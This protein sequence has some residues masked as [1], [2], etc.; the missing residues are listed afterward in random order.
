MTVRRVLC[1]VLEAVSTQNQAQLI[2]KLFIQ[3]GY[4]FALRRTITS[5][6]FGSEDVVGAIWFQLAGAAFLSDAVVPYLFIRDKQKIVYVTI[7][8]IPTKGNFIH[9]NIPRMKFTAVSNFVAKCLKEA[10]LT[11]EGVVHHGVDMDLANYV[12]SMA[13]MRRKQL[14]ERFGD[15][16]K[17]L[18]VGRNDPRKGLNL[19]A[20]AVRMLNEKGLSK[21][22]VV[23][24]IT[25]ESAMAKFRG[26]NNV[27]LLHKQGE[28]KYSDVILNMAA[29]DYGV[30]PTIC[31]GFGLPLLEQNS[32][33]R[34]VLHAWFEPLS[35][36][37]SKDYNY[38]YNYLD[39]EYVRCGDT[40]YW[41]FHLYP[42]Q[43][44]A[45][46]MRDAIDLIRNSR[47]EYEHYCSE[48]MKGAANWDYRITYQPFLRKFGYSREEREDIKDEA[49]K[50]KERLGDSDALGIKKGKKKKKR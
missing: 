12:L 14:D 43:W 10:N 35:E 1:N 24:M 28:L 19:L 3:H 20:S 11:V 46:V 49:K 13:E 42:P 5:A 31:E 26:L 15:R 4:D 30:F 38:T 9:S 25:D 44:L 2:R 27:N 39:T 34:P 50:A 7:E 32:V 17:F 41:F 23:L 8:G 22:F 16:V 18:F 47:E 33:G 36:F 48:A 45:E 21:D 29:V 40:Q 6:E 37:S